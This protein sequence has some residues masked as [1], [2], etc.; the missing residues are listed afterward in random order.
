MHLR[1]HRP[2]NKLTSH[3]IPKHFFPAISLRLNFLFPSSNC[4]RLPQ[5]QGTQS[6]DASLRKKLLFPKQAFFEE[7]KTWKLSAYLLELW[8]VWNSETN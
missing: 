2:S 6:Q 7:P 1:Y 8:N 4:S 5:R 3:Q